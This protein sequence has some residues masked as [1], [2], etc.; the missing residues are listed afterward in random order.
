M[1]LCLYFNYGHFSMEWCAFKTKYY[2]TITNFSSSTGAPIHCLYFASQIC[3]PE[4]QHYNVICSGTDKSRTTEIVWK[5][6]QDKESCELKPGT[7]EQ[8]PF[9]PCPTIYKYLK[10]EYYCTGG[11]TSETQEF[12]T[13][14][15]KMLLYL[16]KMKKK[17]HSFGL[18]INKTS[19]T[20]KKDAEI[21]N[22]IRKVT[23]KQNLMNIESIRPSGSDFDRI[24]YSLQIILFVFLIV[25]VKY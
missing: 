2:I 11:M 4:N 5:L 18:Q 17:S 14:S 1:H 21:K 25:L 6:C 16:N 10:V 15:T 22:N 7:L 12:T 19:N 24:A 9:D 23:V 20:L 8:F 3:I 13:S